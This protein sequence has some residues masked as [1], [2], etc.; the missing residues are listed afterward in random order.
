MNASI[1]PQQWTV[2]R[3]SGSL[4]A[5]VTGL[6]IAD[7]SEQEISSIKN[8]LIQHQVLF[9]PGQ[10][11]SRQ[12]HVSFGEHFGP[13]EGHPNL[14]SEPG[15]HPKIFK[16]VASQGGIADEWHTDITFQEQPAVMSILH[17]VTCPEV[18]GDTMWTNLYQAYNELSDPMKELCLGL[19]ALHDAHPHN[20]SEQMAIHPVVRLHPET[21]LPALYVNEHF[22]RRIVELNAP[23]SEVLLSYLTKWVSSPRFTIRYQW[24]AGTICMW[25]NRCTQHFVINDFQEERV[26]ERV[27]VMG[28]Q[29]T[30]AK[31]SPW[32]PHVH[33]G[34][35]SAKSRHDRQLFNFLT[36]S[37]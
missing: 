26:I 7:L 30:A 28:D 6:K 34:P 13:L 16:L 14:K 36:K 27:T 17:M 32:Q 31:E 20:H 1:A 22:T 37:T 4:G 8:L 29:V 23:E 25:D 9:F 12:E 19:T 15:T 2:K 10:H 24:Q 35:L 5:E 3:L 11:L 21:Q 33:S 18:G